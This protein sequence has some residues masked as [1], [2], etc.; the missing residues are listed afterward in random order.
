MNDIQKMYELFLK[1]SP[2]SKIEV[3]EAKKDLVHEPKIRKIN[4]SIIEQDKH[5]KL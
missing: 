5:K 4:V 3:K 1:S 2:K